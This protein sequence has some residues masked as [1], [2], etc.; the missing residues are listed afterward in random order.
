MKVSIVIP[1]YNGEQWVGKCLDSLLMQ[2]L[3]TDEYEII[4]VDDGSTHSIESL[5]SYVN[6]YPHIHYIH[7]RNQKHAAARNYGLTMAKGDYVFFCD[8]DDFVAKNVLGRLCDLAASETADI[9]LF[10]SRSLDEN[11]IPPLPKRNFDDVK[12]FETGLSYMSQPPH[13]YRGGVW[14][15]LIRRG[16][17]EEKNV[18][19]APEM[20]NREECLF[21]LQ[22]LLASGKVL[23]VDV[24]VYYYVQHPTS[25]VHLEGKV[26]HSEAYVGC[27]V[28]YLEYLTR[29]RKR[30]AEDGKVSPGLLEAM[31]K[32]E[33][34]EALYILINKFRFSSIKANKEM[35]NQLS[36]L[37]Y[38]PI[39]NKIG[40]Y[41]WIRLIA[42][43]YHLWMALCCCYYLM[44]YKLRNRV[45]SLLLTFKR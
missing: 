17:M 41:D 40:K 2:D 45:V 24:D 25:W 21:F 9:L 43:V 19:F 29:T 27:Q 35:I 20:V 16:F 18:R 5:M 36:Y 11:E 31:Q 28:V 34:I 30:L 39:R 26:Y 37:E 6:D 3:K 33:A 13:Q 10:N 15:F 1:Y 7:Q 12:S 23:K 32:G 4:V 8:C 38:Y 44:P 14:Q 42:N 22:M